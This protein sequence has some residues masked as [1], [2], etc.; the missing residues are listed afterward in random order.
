MQLN[1]GDTIIDYLTIKEKRNLFKLQVILEQRTAELAYLRACGRIDSGYV[2]ELNQTINGLTMQVKQ[3]L[4][5]K[6]LSD[7]AYDEMVKANKAIKRQLTATKVKAWAGG[8]AGGFG[9][10]GAGVGVAFII[11]KTQ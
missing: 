10:F 1:C 11:L 8:I 6:D 7:S 5:A 4:Y 9:A 2:A 3:A